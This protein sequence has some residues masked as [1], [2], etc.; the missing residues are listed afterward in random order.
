MKAFKWMH[1]N[2]IILIF[3]P[4]LCY[5]ASV[6]LSWQ[7]SD[8]L[9]ISGYNIYYSTDSRSYGI[10][11]FVGKVNS[12]VLDGLDEGTKYYFAITAVDS[13]ENESGFSTEVVKEISALPVLESPVT[14]TSIVSNLSVN[15]GRDYT[16]NSGLSD[17]ALAFI[18]HATYQY[19]SVPDA[20]KGA[21]YIQTAQRDRYREGEEEVL[22]FNINKN[23]T[24]YVVH[25]DRITTKPAWLSDFVDTG[26]DFNFYKKSS[27][28]SKEFLA[29]RVTLGGNGFSPDNMYTVIISEGGS[30]GGSIEGSID[31]VDTTSPSIVITSP[32]SDGSYETDQPYISLSGTGS[33]NIGVTTVTWANSEGGSGSATGT[34]NWTISDV[35][36]VEGD[37]NITLMAM[38]AADNKA[39]KSLVVTYTSPALIIS[40]LSVHSGRVYTVN[41]GLSDGALAFIDHDTY[42]Y[43][44]VP[45]VLKGAVYIQTAQRDRYREGEEVLSFN[46]NK[47][48]TIYVVHDDKITTKP[49]W[50]SGFVDTGYNFNFYRTSSVYS[51]KFSAGR[52]VLGGNGSSPDNMYTVIISE[53]GTIEGSMDTVDTT[54]S[55][56]VITSPVSGDNYETDQPSISLSGTASDNIGVETVAWGRFSEGAED[57]R[58]SSKEAQYANHD[59]YSSQWI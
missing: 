30:E 19:N 41:S 35:T 32:V 11:V 6:T 42:Q 9:S 52:V 8:D 54:T 40:N 50:L 58:R 49:N 25:D 20:L 22:S 48:A 21:V 2:L 44:S 57:A 3:F 24:I 26:Y 17:E 13:A 43:S 53:D 16:V 12:Y 46:I 39:S 5:S 18:D 55:S 27:V 1:L 4:V 47:N 7:K 34:K 51:K 38:D 59:S 28:Y 37:N 14:D 56:I 33:D 31:T 10:P 45:D 23:A 36:L 15:S 29:G